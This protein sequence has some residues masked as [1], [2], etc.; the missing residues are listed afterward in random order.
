MLLINQHEYKSRLK[1]YRQ[2]VNRITKSQPLFQLVNYDKRGKGNFHLDH[3]ISI[4]FGFDNNI[5]PEIIGNICNLRYVYYKDNLSKR[6]HLTD[7]SF[8]VIGYFINNGTL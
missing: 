1:K 7:E 6:N 3:I 8:D 2:E 5:D 4:K